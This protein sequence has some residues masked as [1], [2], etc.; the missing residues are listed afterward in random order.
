VHCC[1]VRILEY[2]YLFSNHNQLRFTW[3]NS[4]LLI[5]VVFCIEFCLFGVSLC[6]VLC[7]QCSQWLWIVHPDCLFG[8]L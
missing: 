7:S 3:C 4:V 2:N 5:F 1:N 6:S 8:F